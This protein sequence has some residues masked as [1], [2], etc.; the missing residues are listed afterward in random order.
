M[1]SAFES[2]DSAG[3]KDALKNFI[4]LCVDE[5]DEIEEDY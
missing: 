5:Q 2:K 3:F 4:R 1:F